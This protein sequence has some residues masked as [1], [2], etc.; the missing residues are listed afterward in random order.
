MERKNLDRDWIVSQIEAARVKKPVGNATL[1]I[2]EFVDSLN[3]SNDTKSQAFEL[4]SKIA[5]GHA[6][7]EEVEDEVWIPVRPGDIRTAEQI[8]V[9]ADA[10][11]GDVGAIH[12]GRR[13]VV[14]GVR[15]GDVIIKTTDGKDPYLEGAHYS[16]HHLEKL[17]VR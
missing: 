17:V 6:I 16:P 14:I 3:I 4:A 9:R 2:V 1:K 7:L 12:N 13:G 15:Y 10:F 5:L 11:S 8:R